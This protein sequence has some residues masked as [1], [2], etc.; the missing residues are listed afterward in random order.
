MHISFQNGIFQRSNTNRLTSLVF[1]TRKHKF[2]AVIDPQDVEHKDLN[3]ESL[4]QNR[5]NF[6]A[7]AP[8]LRQF[9]LKLS[10]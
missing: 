5:R 1:I 6:P 2:D 3:V 8:E 10:I 7:I 9:A 4:M